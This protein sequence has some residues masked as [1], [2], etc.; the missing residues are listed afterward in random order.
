MFGN[1]IEAGIHQQGQAPRGASATLFLSMF[2]AVLM[3]YY[4]VN[5]ARAAREARA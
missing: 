4:L 5:V 3:I 1:A 2:V